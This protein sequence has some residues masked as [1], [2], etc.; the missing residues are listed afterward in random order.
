[1]IRI[2]VRAALILSLASITRAGA[3]DEAGRYA[4]IGI[5]RPH[6]GDTVDFEAGYARHLEWHR[7][8]GDRWTW[9]GWTIAIG[10]RQR[11][12][13]YATFGHSADSLDNPVSPA[14]DER[15]TIP[16]ITP[17]ARFISS[18]LFEFLP[19]L[20]RGSGVPQPAARAEL[21]TVELVPGAERAFE[22][23][24]TAAQ[25]SLRGETLWYR[26]ISGGRVPCYVRLRPRP[27]LAAIL[28]SVGE[29]RLAE[30]TN[31]LIASEI[32]EVLTLRPAMSY[33]LSLP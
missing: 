30:K 21:S 25:K 31:G 12:F 22:D 10:E 8:A 9:Y 15:D 17:H 18:G 11:G 16:N 5:L 7:Q 20:S 33:R 28:D 26:M 2:A 24:L 13:V 32:V 27:T 4:R 6:D 23:A 1:M 14:E 29:Q 19:A 3:Q